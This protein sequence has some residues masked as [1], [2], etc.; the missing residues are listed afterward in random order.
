MRIQRAA[1]TATGTGARTCRRTDAA[2]VTVGL[3]RVVWRVADLSAV[4]KQPFFGNLRR[5]CRKADAIAG[6]R[7]EPSARN[8]RGGNVPREDDP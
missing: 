8:V 5:R 6:T 7:V 3:H 1:A 4:G 2:F